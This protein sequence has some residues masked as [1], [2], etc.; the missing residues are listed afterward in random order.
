MITDEQGRT[1]LLHRN[2]GKHMQWEIPGGKIDAGETAE[3]AAAREIKEELGVDIEILE[4]IGDAGFTQG[5]RKYHYTWF[6]AVVSGGQPKV[7]EPKTF[8]NLEYFSPAQMREIYDQLS[9]NT[10][11]FLNQQGGGKLK[12]V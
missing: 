10:Q 5:R 8:D 3:Q 6:S 4:K 9:P 1:L 11:N 2:N 12:A 7:A